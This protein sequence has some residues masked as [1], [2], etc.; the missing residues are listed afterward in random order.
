MASKKKEV[1]KQKFD[2]GILIMVVVMLLFIVAVIFVFTKDSS[3]EKKLLSENE[4][5][6]KTI[7]SDDRDENNLNKLLER[8]ISVGKYQTYEAS[9]KR[10][11]KD[12]YSNYIN[13]DNIINSDEYKDYVKIE[14]IEKE[15]PNFENTLKSLRSNKD[16]LTESLLALKT[17]STVD[18]AVTY[19]T[20]KDSKA[21]E[22][23][24]YTEELVPSIIIDKKDLDTLEKNI[25]D[26]KDVLEKEEELL[27][28]LKTNSKYWSVI[29]GNIIFYNNSLIDE[30][31]NYL[32]ELK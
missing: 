17:C 5:I 19:L 15:G 6:V 10:Y 1:K 2:F 11:V 20:N 14:T 8:T 22:Y 21:V 3:E 4:K 30:Y 27:L 26:T 24:F 25:E 7:F 31:N 28:F 12:C 13:I 29:E 18:N 23:K 16:K 9:Y 32:K